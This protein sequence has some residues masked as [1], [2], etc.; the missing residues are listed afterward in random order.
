MASVAPAMLVSGAAYAQTTP[1]PTTIDVKSSTV[2]RNVTVTTVE[3][4]QVTTPDTD[5][6]NGD[7]DGDS[8]VGL[9]GLVGLLGLLG[10]AGLGGRKRRDDDVEVTARPPT[11]NPAPPTASGATSRTDRP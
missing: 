2:E 9:W 7:G 5:T 1:P 4:A 10:L 11:M 3:S 6:S 8:K